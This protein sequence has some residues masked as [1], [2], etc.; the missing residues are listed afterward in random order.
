MR[1]PW[2]LFLLLIFATANFC[3]GCLEEE[4][5]ALLQFKHSLAPK[6]SGGLSSWKGNKCCEWQGIGCDN[7]TKHVTMLDL[8]SNISGSYM[9][10]EGNELNSNL[11]ELTHLSYMDLS[12]VHFRS[13]PI[14]DFIGSMTQLRYLYLYF[15]GFSGIIPHGIGNLS[16]LRELDLSGNQLTDSF[17]DRKPLTTPVS[18]FIKKPITNPSSGYHRTP[19]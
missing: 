3:L 5:Q 16:N 10:L 13:I 8:G 12:G 15:A 4:R 1:K 7:A 18:R 17:I 14:P 2:L 11:V 9:Q 19:F 6:P